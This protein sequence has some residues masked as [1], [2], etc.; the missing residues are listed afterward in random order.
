LDW[1]SQYWYTSP[2][3]RPRDTESHCAVSFL[4]PPTQPYVIV[5]LVAADVAAATKD[6][7]EQQQEMKTS[8]TA[9]ARAVT[10]PCLYLIFYAE[11]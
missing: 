4:S 2:R 5:P 9:A 1:E 11:E 7:R 8:A 6:H 10:I 3:N